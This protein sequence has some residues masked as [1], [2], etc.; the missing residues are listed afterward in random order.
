MVHYL[1][2]FVSFMVSFFVKVKKMIDKNQQEL[3]TE[4]EILSCVNDLESGVL[5]TWSQAMALCGRSMYV[6]VLLL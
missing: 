4:M 1:F 3:R 5:E 2:I 6:F